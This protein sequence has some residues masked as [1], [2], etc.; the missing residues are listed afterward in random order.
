MPIEVPSHIKGL[1][2]DL[3]GTIADTMPA[4]YKAW[5]AALGE[6]GVEL[7]E[8]QFYAFGGMPTPRI[9]ELLNDQHDKSMPVMETALRKEALFEAYIP[10]VRPIGAIVDLIERFHGKLPMA[11]ATGGMRFVATKTL[12]A[13]HLLDRFDAFVT[14]EDVRR[15]KPAPDTFLEAARRIN[16]PPGECMAFE[17][18][19]LGVES[20]TAAGMLVLDVRTLG[21]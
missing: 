20:A 2:F 10:A 13:L 18:A 21:L 8:Q 15:G 14:V 4:H 9:I 17:D 19:D 7:P 6:H 3:D 11:V 12:E 16:V 5:V 1:V